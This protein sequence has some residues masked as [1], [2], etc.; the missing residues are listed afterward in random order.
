MNIAFGNRIKQIRSINKISQMQFAQSLNCSSSRVQSWE[1]RKTVP[2]ADT[3][4]KISRK[5]KVSIDY[6]LGNEN[7][8]KF[9]NPKMQ[10]LVDR[11]PRFTEQEIIKIIKILN[12][13]FDG[14]CEQ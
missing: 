1:N 14:I 2:S 9:L 5:Y 10:Y 7:A 12:A 6:L 3:L 13:V 11:L 4:M 8:N